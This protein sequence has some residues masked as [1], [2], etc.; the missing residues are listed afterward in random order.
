MSL[1]EET[2]FPKALTHSLF[3]LLTA[4][5]P[6]NSISNHYFT[7]LYW[8]V[9]S[10]YFKWMKPDNLCYCDWL[11]SLRWW[12]W[13]SMYEY[14]ITFNCQTICHFMDT[15][16]FVYSFFSWWTFGLF[17]PL[18]IINNVPINMYIYIYLSTVFNSF[19]YIPRSGNAGS[20]R[21]FLCLTFSRTDKPFSIPTINI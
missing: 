2:L 10:G 16:H 7:F 13:R 9:F 5:T 18:V 19:R 15:Q 1:Q 6:F 8:T 12:F 11:L 17:L 4:L 3:P 14:F 20:Y 21:N